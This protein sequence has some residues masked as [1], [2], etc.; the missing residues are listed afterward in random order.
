MR[1]SIAKDVQRYEEVYIATDMQAWL[2]KNAQAYQHE[3]KYERAAAVF[4]LLHVLADLAREEGH[5]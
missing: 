1:R 3:G 5:E 2:E 4:A